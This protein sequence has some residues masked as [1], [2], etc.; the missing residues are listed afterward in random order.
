MA[1]RQYYEY[2]END[3]TYGRL[4]GTDR[5]IIMYSMEGSAARMP[6]PNEE[7]T[8]YT[9]P[10]S[11]R[12]QRSREIRLPL[13]LPTAFFLS[14]SVVFVAFMLYN[15]LHVSNQSVVYTKNIANLEKQYEALR[16]ANDALELNIRTYTD[17]EYVYRIATEELG[18][19][20]PTAEQIRNFTQTESEYVVQY[21]AIPGMDD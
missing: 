6:A 10:R 11:R 8:P 1:Q 7:E 4:S 12:E 16:D 15:Y 9:D 18:M 5:N 3:R 2:E 20:V 13:N 21:D 17:Y 19:Q 14:M